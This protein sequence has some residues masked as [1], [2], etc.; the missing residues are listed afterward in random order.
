MFTF[1]TLKKKKSSISHDELKVVSQL[2]I[3]E[4]HSNE[5][6]AIHDNLIGCMF[7]GEKLKACS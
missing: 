5:T 1:K 3:A 6:K 4:T 7:H 2:S